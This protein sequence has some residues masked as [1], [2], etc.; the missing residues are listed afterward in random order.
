MVYLVKRYFVKRGISSSGVFGQTWYFVKRGI[1][2]SG[3]FEQEAYLV[4]CF[5]VIYW[6]DISGVDRNGVERTVVE[7][8]GRER[9]NSNGV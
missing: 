5:R 6:G 2:S 3:V 1:W 9:G 4:T 8:G 7:A